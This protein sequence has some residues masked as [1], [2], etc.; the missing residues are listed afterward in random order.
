M[1]GR[2]LSRALQ[3]HVGCPDKRPLWGWGSGQKTAGGNCGANFNAI[4]IEQ[5]ERV[6]TWMREEQLLVNSNRF[7]HV[8]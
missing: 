1:G 2:Q 6:V 3:F 8:I 5:A 7:L 4:A